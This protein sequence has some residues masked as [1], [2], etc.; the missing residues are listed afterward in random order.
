MRDM[1]EEMVDELLDSDGP[2]IV[3]GMPFNASAILREMDPT[4]YRLM[5]SD[6]AD[7][8]ISDLQYELDGL[9]PEVDADEIADI[10]DRI[11]ALERL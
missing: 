11:D 1:I 7:I 2:V 8:L 4:A 10:Q 6:I 9:D 5:Y 3:A